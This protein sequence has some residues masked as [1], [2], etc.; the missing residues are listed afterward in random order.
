MI[1]FQFRTR[2][3]GYDYQLRSAGVHAAAVGAADAGAVPAVPARAGTAVGHAAGR[4]L[5][6]DRPVRRH[7]ARQRQ[8]V[9]SRPT[10][11]RFASSFESAAIPTTPAALLARAGD[12]GFRRPYL[13][14]T[15]RCPYVLAARHSR[16]STAASITRSPSSRT[17]SAGCSRSIC[18]AKLPPRSL[19]TSDFQVL[20]QATVSN[21]MRYDMTSHLQLPRCGGAAALMSRSARCTCRAN[22]N[23][24]SARARAR[25]AQSRAGRP[26]LCRTTVLGMFRN[27]K[28]FYT[29]T[30]PLLGTNPVDE[31]LF[32]TLAGFASIM[33]RRSRC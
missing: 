8:P 22:A 32:A 15:A 10:R 27:Q 11:S 17:A 24:R 3:P 6:R 9:C 2:Q 25:V 14:R 4:L 29:T 30:P 19:M 7:V 16:R 20:F 13:E 1:G 28:F 12:V 23:P 33:R 5:R 31:F 26:R 18:P 21:R